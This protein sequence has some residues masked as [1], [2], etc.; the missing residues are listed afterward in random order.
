MSAHPTPGQTPEN[1]DVVFLLEEQHQTIRLLLAKVL[2]ETGTERRESFRDLMQRLIVHETTE[3]EIVHPYAR[4]TIVNGEQLVAD[5]LLEEES[6]KQALVHL[7]LLD[8]DSPEFVDA[9]E[10]L[11]QEVLAH[12]DAEEAREFA[13]LKERGDPAELQALAQAVRAAAVLAP[14]H[15]RPGLTSAKENILAGPATAAVY[16]RARDAIRKVVDEL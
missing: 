2:D 9:F 12:D 8:P 6:L 3:E 15:P 5:R 16:D 13:P 11:R 10:Q 4:H 14:M 7:E 1:N